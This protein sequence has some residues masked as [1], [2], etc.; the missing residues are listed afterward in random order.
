MAG[1][2]Q[3]ARLQ[4]M[5]SQ[6]AGSF[7]M[8]N[9]GGAGQAYAQ[10]I[11]DYNAPELDANDEGSLLARQRWAQSNGYQDEANQLGVRLGEVGAANQL[12]AETDDKNARLAN[13]FGN[14]IPGLPENLQDIARGMRDGLAT[15]DVSYMDAVKFLQNPQGGSDAPAAVREYEFFKNLDPEAQAEYQNLKRSGNIIDL[16]GGG[17]GYRGQDGNVQ[18]LVSPKDA[19]ALNADS[20]RS[21]A[22]SSAEGG[23]ASEDQQ[24]AF[25]NYT[26]TSSQI[27]LYDEA[28]DLLTG[29][30]AANT[31]AVYQLLPTVEARTVELENVRNRLGLGRIAAGK[32]GQL[33]EIEMQVA[34]ETEIPV[35]LPPKELRAWL[36]NR[37]SAEQK[38]LA[39][40]EDYLRWA[41]ETK[42]TKAEWRTKQW[43]ASA[44]KDADNNMDPV[45]NKVP[46]SNYI[47]KTSQNESAEPERDLTA[48]EIL[49]EL[50]IGGG[51]R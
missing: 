41:Q 47:L 23:Q 5:L 7:S 42:G 14:A 48:D 2:D 10:N 17:V 49:A 50:G 22:F 34:F 40:E 18:V 16:G 6:L 36:E 19:T 15:G 37:K 3:S 25:E 38:L 43:I 13:M 46:E 24:A 29:D 44:D 11:R 20:A 33:T 39:L 51:S 21:S 1:S 28:L 31:G 4:G 45:T 30:D 9:M 12:K 8:E 32:F 27:A 26:N 35:G